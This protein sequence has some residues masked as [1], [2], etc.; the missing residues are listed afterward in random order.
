MTEDPA[1][2]PAPLWRLYRLP[3]MFGGLSLFF[4]IIAFVLLIKTTQISE[5]IRF[6]DEKNQGSESGALGRTVTVDIGGAVNNP[7]V[8][9]LEEGKRIEDAIIA[10]GGLS[11]EAD[12]DKISIDINRAALLLDG[13]K[14]YIPKKGESQTVGTS[15]NAQKTI[16]VNINTASEK[17]LDTLPGIGEVTA[18]KIISGRPYQTLEELVSRKIMS[19]SVFEKIKTQLTL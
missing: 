7:G 4:L 1:P 16:S 6:H 3:I 19:Q 5:P 15:N 9:T 17:E 18:Q 2:T 10:A 11:S 12:N 13:A 14:L 8:Y